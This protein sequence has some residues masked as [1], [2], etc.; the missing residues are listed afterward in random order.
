MN[1]PTWSRAFSTLGCVGFSL[2]DSLRLAARHHMDAIELR[3]I[4]GSLDLPGQLEKTFGTP[5]AFAAEAGSNPI[6]ICSLDTSLRLIGNTAADRNDF[7]RHLPWAEA[8]GVPRL[9]VFDGGTQLDDAQLGQALD[10]LS[11]WNDLRQ[12]N[13]WHAD[14]M[15]ETHDAFTRTP[16]ILRFLAR[17]PANTG[18]L[19]DTHHTWR[20]GGEEIAGTWQAIRS[21]VVH[22]HVKDSVSRPPDD[23]AYTHVPPG[24]GEFAMS[25]LRGLLARDGY[26]GAV[27]LEWERHWH[28]AL[29]TLEDALTS[30]T[31]RQWW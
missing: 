6:R 26:T 25:T 9:R 13:G 21:H 28:P 23:R 8:L 5:E 31:A 2:A 22:I 10:T 29:A 12:S 20:L 14:V 27:S 16:A 15:V 30:A 4:G 1:T 19:W 11:W 3:G 17:A 24:Q 7:L 18:V